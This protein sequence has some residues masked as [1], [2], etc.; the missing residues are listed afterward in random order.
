MKRRACVCDGQPPFKVA[1]C[2]SCYEK[3]LRARNPEF[4]ERQRENQ[5]GWMARADN[6]E[7]A[8]TKRA[9]LQKS[10]GSRAHRQ[11]RITREEYDAYLSQPCGICGAPSKH[12]DHDHSCC[13][14]GKGC[15]KC[16]RGGL[17]HRCN[18]GVGYLE[19]W[20]AENRDAALAW[21][22]VDFITAMQNTRP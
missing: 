9:E 16:I 12:L 18:L 22:A 6:A 11:Y 7:R 1:K 17:C 2:R 21:I 13:S 3:D 14:V 10:A 15:P 5:R 4:A 19:G 8:R 20:F